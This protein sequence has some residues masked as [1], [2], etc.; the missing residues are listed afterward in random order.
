MRKSHLPLLPSW[1]SHQ[2]RISTEEV[3]KT[4]AADSGSATEA[5]SKRAAKAA[6]AAAA[7]SAL[8]AGAATART[9]PVIITATA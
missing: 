1:T 6:S 5:A 8:E 2:I 7:T 9:T 3:S 4:T